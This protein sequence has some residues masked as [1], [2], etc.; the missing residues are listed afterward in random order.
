MKLN[1]THFAIAQAAGKDEYR[2][3]LTKLEIND[4]YICA[5]DGCMLAY[6]PNTDNL[7]ECQIPAKL[8]KKSTLKAFQI[9]EN[10]ELITHNNNITSTIS[11]AKKENYPN[12]EAVMDKGET[13]HTVTL[14]LEVLER[15]VKVL[16][17]SG[18]KFITLEM[19]E[20]S[21]KPIHAQIKNSDIKMVIMPV[22]NN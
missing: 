18:E 3:A 14:G 1:N 5:S 9:I 8:I 4:K 10:D 21:I 11:L 16:K 13:H 20:D 17:A 22:K 12:I 7:P 2:P 6:T 15:V 19:Q